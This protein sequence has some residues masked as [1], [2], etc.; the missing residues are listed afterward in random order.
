MQLSIF[1][2]VDVKLNPVDGHDVDGEILVKGPNVTSGYWNKPEKTKEVMNDG[3]FC[4]GDL[5]RLDKDGFLYITG[6]IKDEFKLNNGKFVAGGNL[7]KT[8]NKI[9]QVLQ[10]VVFPSA[11]K[12]YVVAL[13]VPNSNE[14]NLEQKIK[15]ELKTH[16]ADFAPYERIKNFA[17]VKEPFTEQNGLA[18][19]TQKIKRS[20]VAKKYAD[21]IAKL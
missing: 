21:V 14:E 3:W 12:E 17:L 19:P 18:T 13:I 7:E 8:I 5:G 20:A 4:T 10:S 16:C 6:R 15:D 11:N 9:P 2:E 1:P